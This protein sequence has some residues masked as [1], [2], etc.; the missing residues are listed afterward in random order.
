MK[1]ENEIP[2]DG[3]I[4]FGVGYIWKQAGMLSG[5]VNVLGGDDI[6]TVGIHE[7]FDVI[8]RLDRCDGSEGS[9]GGI[10]KSCP[11]HSGGAAAS[12]N[13]VSSCVLYGSV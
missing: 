3:G 4:F 1:P 12:Y 8:R 10:H 6:Y 13:G 11:A 5:A 2:P 7:F 9:C